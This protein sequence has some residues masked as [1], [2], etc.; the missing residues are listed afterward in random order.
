ME[1]LRP[2]IGGALLRALCVRLS[3]CV[4][5]SLRVCLCV[6]GGGEGLRARAAESVCTLTLLPTWWLRHRLAASMSVI[7]SPC[8][9]PLFAA[10]YQQP[11]SLP[12]CPKKPQVPSPHKT[13]PTWWLRHRLAAS[14]SVIHSP[15]ERPHVSAAQH[16]ACCCC[17]ATNLIPS[18]PLEP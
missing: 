6:W 9:R 5:V 14:T 2:H 16:A 13:L 4:C 8:E 11:P 18:L 15:C 1:K 7:H 12:A 10:A 17:A 3:L